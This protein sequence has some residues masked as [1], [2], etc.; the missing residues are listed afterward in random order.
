MPRAFYLVSEQ[1]ALMERTARVSANI[2]DRVKLAIYVRQND[3][4]C[5]N[6]H[7]LH[8]AS[9]DF[10]SGRNLHKISQYYSTTSVGD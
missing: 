9:R 6:G 10:S 8:H 4:L 3:L 5:S 1:F 2:P 7:F